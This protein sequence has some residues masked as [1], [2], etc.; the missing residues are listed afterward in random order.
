L[1]CPTIFHTGKQESRFLLEDLHPAWPS[2]IRF[3]PYRE[4]VIATS[5]GTPTIIGSFTAWLFCSINVQNILVVNTDNAVSSTN[6]ETGRTCQA[7]PA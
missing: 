5:C 6:A 3:L 1:G 4:F 2:S 7:H